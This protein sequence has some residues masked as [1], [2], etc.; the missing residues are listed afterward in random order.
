MKIIVLSGLTLAL[1]LGCSSPPPSTTESSTDQVKTSSA[2]TL[3]NRTETIASEVSDTQQTS[4]PDFQDYPA[5]DSFSGTPAPVDLT[6]HPQARRFRTVLRQGA[7][8]GPNFAGKYTV[9]TWG[10]GTSCQVVGIINAETGSVYI[11]DRPAEAG[12][13][14]Q[15]DSRLLVVNPPENFPDNE[16]DWMETRYYVWDGTQ[17][18]EVSASTS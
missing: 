15:L 9:V 5:T 18:T 10:C 2:K 6:S 3:N 14:F 1:A 4:P 17:L 8:Q 16:P 7:K 13:K 12:V 11:L